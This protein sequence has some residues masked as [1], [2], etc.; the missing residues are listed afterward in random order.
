MTWRRGLRTIPLLAAAGAVS[1]CG[2]ASSTS[3]STSPI[4]AASTQAAST[5]PPQVSGCPRQ[6]TGQTVTVT[7]TVTLSLVIGAN[8]DVALTDAQGG[9]C[10][11]VTNTDPGANGSHAVY[12][13]YVAYVSPG[14][15]PI[16]R[17]AFATYAATDK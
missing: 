4:A 10:Q 2:A 11:I 1:A 3:V 17:V 16:N 6:F 7:G 8:W 5:S 14:T 13:N 9:T 12:T 15:P